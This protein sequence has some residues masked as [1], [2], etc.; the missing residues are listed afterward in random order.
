MENK[1]PKSTIRPVTIIAILLAGII[2]LMLWTFLVPGE[3]GEYNFYGGPILPMSSLSGAENVTAERNVT[4][5]FSDFAEPGISILDEN[6]VIVTDSYDLTNTSDQNVTV[7]LVWGFEG[8]FI[9][10]PEQIPAITVDG[11]TVQ[12]RMYPATD[13]ES[14]LHLADSFERY[15][16]V[17]TENDFLS[18]AM[19]ETP[20]WDVPVKVYH[21]YDLEYEG[22]E[23][24]DLPLL[25]IKYTLGKSTN[26]WT[27]IYQSSSF[28]QDI[29]RYRLSFRVSWGEAWLYVVG[30]DLQDMQ[31]GGN[32]GYNIDEDTVIEG[33][34]YELEIYES[35]FMDCLWE[36]AQEYQYEPGPGGD[37]ALDLVTPEIFFDGAMKRIVDTNYQNP[38]D[39]VRLMDEILGSVVSDIRMLYWVFPV[40]IPAGETVT[41]K[42]IYEQEASHNGSFD[43]LH[44]FDL[45]TTLGSNL[46]FTKQSASV[47]NTQYITIADGGEGQNF[48]FDP[49]NGVTEVELDLQ[50]ER[51]FLD[52]SIPE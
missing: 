12:M 45:A 40:E 10:C 18:I 39:R 43:R 5:D 49:A 16:K 31:I 14:Q 34:T 37:P 50:T 25:D 4:L 32:Q 42:G 27:R 2:P 7:E 1:R 52:I 8:Q 35:T 22:E 33:V 23:P 44:G 15:K 46:N 24:Y 9:D 26:L 51:Y 38:S 41:V 13:V 19:A 6:T 17:L 11:E 36:C 48:G 30:D 29:D 3:A 21:F 28:D 47:A 20:Q